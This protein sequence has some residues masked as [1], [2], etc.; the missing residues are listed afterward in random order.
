MKALN[1]GKL[2][3]KG[4]M[5]VKAEVRHFFSGKIRVIRTVRIMTGGTGGN[6]NRRMD[7]PCARQCFL[8]VVVTAETCVIQSGGEQLFS[9]GTVRVMAGRTL[10]GGG[11]SMLPRFCEGSLVMAI[12]A[13]HTQI[14][15][16]QKESVVRAMGMVTV[17]AVAIPDRRMHNRTFPGRFVTGSTELFTR[18]SQ[19]ETF[20]ALNRVLLQSL[21]VAG[22]AITVFCRT[23]RFFRGSH[24]GMAGSRDT[25]IG[26]DSKRRSQ[27]NENENRHQPE[28]SLHTG[29]LNAGF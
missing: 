22:E 27:K 14:A 19:G 10:A 29:S 26:G 20:L 8:D 3:F 12:E 28:A 21:L 15:I 23:V 11:R 17:E 7:I 24:R 1:F 25:G 2:L 6:F 4:F 5:A 13:E 18:G 16:S 9:G